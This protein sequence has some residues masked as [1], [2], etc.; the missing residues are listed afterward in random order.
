M[1]SRDKFYITNMIF[2]G[3]FDVKAFAYAVLFHLA[4][5]FHKIEGDL[6]GTF[7]IPQGTRRWILIALRLFT[8]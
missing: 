2:W 6:R 4:Y 5:N 1:F 7:Q 8:K 3:F